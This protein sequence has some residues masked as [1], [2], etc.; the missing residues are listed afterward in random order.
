MNDDIASKCFGAGQ[1]RAGGHDANE[2]AVLTAWL[3]LSSS[4]VSTCCARPC[5]VAGKPGDC[6]ARRQVGGK[7]WLVCGLRDEVGRVLVCG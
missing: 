3:V 5:R 2:G 6:V 4:S 1:R 7:R